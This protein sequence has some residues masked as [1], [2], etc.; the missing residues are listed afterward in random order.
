M[1]VTM[2]EM[3]QTSREHGVIDVLVTSEGTVLWGRAKRFAAKEFRVV[4]LGAW[5]AEIGVTGDR[6]PN[7]RLQTYGYCVIDARDANGRI[8]VTVTRHGDLP[9]AVARLHGREAPEFAGLGWPVEILSLADCPQGIALFVGP[10]GS[11]KTSLS[12][13]LAR[14][15]ATQDRLTWSLAAPVEFEQPSPLVRSYYVGD[16][17]DF[18]QWAH[19]VVAAMTSSVEVLEIGQLEDADTA[20]AAV[21]AARQGKLV[22]ATIVTGNLQQAIAQLLK[23]GCDA[24]DLSQLLIGGAAL[25]LLPKVTAPDELIGAA[26]LWEVDADTRRAIASGDLEGFQEQLRHRGA[27]LESQLHRLAYDER[28]VAVAEARRAAVFPEEV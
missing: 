9:E 16:D 2:A 13:S 15:A 25:R 17:G 6:T 26:E 23:W 3:L 10:G 8:R 24:E 5:L 27:S 18:T 14:Y 11:G 22:L 7:V 4:D 1:D 21:D 19:G 28:V 20:Q 12:A